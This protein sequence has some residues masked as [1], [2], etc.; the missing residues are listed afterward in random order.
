VENIDADQG[1]DITSDHS[2]V[3]CKLKTHMKCNKRDRTRRVQRDFGDLSKE[4]IYVW[5]AHN[6]QQND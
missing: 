6:K 2:P 3:V 1:T 4:D 5:H